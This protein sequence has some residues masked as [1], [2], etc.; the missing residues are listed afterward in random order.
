M[1][2]ERIE[3]YVSYFFT[4]TSKLKYMDAVRNY[5]LQDNKK[6]LHESSDFRSEF[7]KG[8]FIFYLFLHIFVDTIGIVSS[9]YI[10]NGA[11]PWA[12]C[13]IGL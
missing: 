6:S 9:D 4:S 12:T 3:N 10:S 7:L 13:D 8:F 5:F 2:F 1:Q 11:D